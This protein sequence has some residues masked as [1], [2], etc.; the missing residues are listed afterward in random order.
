MLARAGVVVFVG[1]SAGAAANLL[2]GGIRPWH[3]Q[4]PTACDASEG[5]E[6]PLEI[7]PDEAATMC[8]RT[9]VVI[10]D[11]RP[12][13]RFAEGHIAGSIHLPCTASGPIA[14]GALAHFVGARTIIVYGQDTA[15]AVPVAASLRRR[16]AGD[17]RVL[18]G[19]F[20]GWEKAGLACASG[21]CD[22][23]KEPPT[24]APLKDPAK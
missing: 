1:G 10:A 21:P 12:A 17:V 19:G 18:R 2:H 4:P 23:C 16:H 14:D 6:T 8:G 24:K 7:E 11:A 22:E 3:Y 13:E 15:E 5:V 9:D 20:S